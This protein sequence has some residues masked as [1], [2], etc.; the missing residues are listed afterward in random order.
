VPD[1]KA[2]CAPSPKKAGDKVVGVWIE[3]ASGAK[4]ERTE[5][6][7]VLAL[8]Q[9]RKIDVILVTELTRWG[10]SML[11]LFRTLQD[12]RPGTCRWWL[13]TGLQSISIARREN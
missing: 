5:R 6:K 1:R 10:R 8:A 7:R 9:A 4:G 13:R 12:Y 11:D 3:T 2:I